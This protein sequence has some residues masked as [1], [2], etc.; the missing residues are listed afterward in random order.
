MNIHKYALELEDYGLDQEEI[1]AIITL[2]KTPKWEVSKIDNSDVHFYK[3]I[4]VRKRFYNQDGEPDVVSCRFSTTC[5]VDELFL[6]N[7]EQALRG[8]EHV[9]R[10]KS[11]DEQ[12]EWEGI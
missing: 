8:M 2:E 3:T 12:L 1:D 7:I 4:E 11:K 5:F 10:Q 6:K 9:A